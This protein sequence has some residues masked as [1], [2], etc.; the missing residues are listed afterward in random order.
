M[1]S[2]VCHVWILN[3]LGTMWEVTGLE[4]EERYLSIKASVPA[5]GLL[6]S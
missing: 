6:K 2:E 3:S 4:Q 5:L 1:F